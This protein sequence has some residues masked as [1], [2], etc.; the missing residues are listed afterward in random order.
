MEVCSVHLSCRTD[1]KIIE[2]A[3]NM[4]TSF[5]F[6]DSVGNIY[7]YKFNSVDEAR[8]FAYVHGLC[9]LGS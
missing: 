5:K 2:G 3:G 4:E 8:H 9:F 6:V 7:W 1:G